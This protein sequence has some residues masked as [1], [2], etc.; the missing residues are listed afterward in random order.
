[1]SDIKKI[2]TVEERAATFA[3]VAAR[4]AA[5]AEEARALQDDLTLLAESSTSTVHVDDYLTPMLARIS[6]GDDTAQAALQGTVHRASAM[7]WRAFLAQSSA[8]ACL[9]AAR[10][11]ELT[12]Q[13]HAQT[14]GEWIAKGKQPP[15]DMWPL[16]TEEAARDIMGQLL[17]SA[18]QELQRALR[19]VWNR[20]HPKL[21]TNAGAGFGAKVIM[22]RACECKWG[23]AALT[24]EGHH[25]LFD[26]FRLLRL[27]DGGKPATQRVNGWSE[28]YASWVGPTRLET[29]TCDYFTAK[30]HKNGNVHITFTDMDL[31]QQVNLFMAHGDRRA[32]TR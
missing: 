3:R 16:F 14:R 32:L 8:D 9:S 19:D 1:M 4:T 25:T 11:S 29:L 6:R 15:A 17:G 7:A 23:P 28:F 31:V 27:C 10:C 22:A 21:K 18:D 30:L 20:L 12:W 13:L 2:I 24:D 26:L 5:I